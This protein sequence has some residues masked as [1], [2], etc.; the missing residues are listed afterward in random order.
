MTPLIGFAPDLPAQTPGVLTDCQAIVPSVRG[1]KAAPSE[2]DSTLP[3]PSSNQIL[4]AALLEKIDGTTRLLAAD[5]DKIYEATSATAW[6]ERGSSYST[7][8]LDRWRFA[9]YGNV[10]LA[11]NKGVK[12]QAS[13]STNFTAI[14][15]APKA[16][17]VE[18]VD[19]FVFVADTNETT[20]GDQNDRW[21]CSAIGDYTDWVPAIATQCTTAR[22]L[23]SNGPIKAVR[24]FGGGV[25]I[26]KERA[27]Y[28]GTYVGPPIV[29]S[30]AEVSNVAGALS[31]EV[32]V[33]I[34][35]QD[36]GYLHIFMGANDFYIFD[37]STPTPIGAPLREWV[38]GRINREH[39]ENCIAEH[40]PKDGL[41]FFYFPTTNSTPDTGVVYNYKTN[42]WG[43]DDRSVEAVAQ[44][45]SPGLIYNDLGS[46]FG[47]STTYG[48][49]AVALGSATY[50]EAFPSDNQRIPMYF[51]TSHTPKLLN[52][53]ATNSALVLGEY[54]DDSVVSSITRVRPRWVQRPISATMTNYYRMN[55]GDSW[56]TDQTVQMGSNRFDVLRSSRWHK[57]TIGMVG[58][59]EVPAIDFQ[60]IEDGEE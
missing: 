7:G 13:T 34:V 35:T 41:V 2:A 43:R 18:T 60:F 48:Q 54:G 22:L 37:G 33:P 6:T 23:Q 12:V 57:F 4:G 29:W 40:R 24:R 28:L 53:P 5:A 36:G 10:S 25:V 59:A 30:F 19:Q 39:T 9:Q 44:Y 47:T 15:S 51:N 26:Y 56:T 55:I 46:A 27:M 58:E 8:S 52:G 45:A 42:Q 16:S 17:I 14:T 31:Q 1:M 38:F 3:A 20:Y 49:L 32:V 21:W 11:T 50:N